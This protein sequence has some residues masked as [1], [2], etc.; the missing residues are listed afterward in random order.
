MID[1]PSLLSK[2]R[3]KTDLHAYVEAKLQERLSLFN[4]PSKNI[5]PIG[6]PLQTKNLEENS[7]ENIQSTLVLHWSDS[8][9][10]TFTDLKKALK[11]KGIFVGALF[12]EATLQELRATFNYV[13]EKNFGHITPR[14]IPLPS[15]H[16]LAGIL[17][18]LNFSSPV[19][20]RE[21]IAQEY[22][23]FEDLLKDLK[24]NALAQRKQGLITPRFFEQTSNLYEEKFTTKNQKIY[25]TFEVVYLMAWHP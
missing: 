1:W 7:F 21:I 14:F 5:T 19:V 18:T 23:S 2:K 11:T 22:D 13:E 24:N 10:Q 3:K 20:D 16:T 6:T 8:Y 25:A 15:A 9:E 12:G 4:I 17:Q